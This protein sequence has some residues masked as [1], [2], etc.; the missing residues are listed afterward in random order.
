MAHNDVVTQVTAYA[1]QW[2]TGGK[3]SW[4]EPLL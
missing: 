3:A 2:E 1:R 4:Y